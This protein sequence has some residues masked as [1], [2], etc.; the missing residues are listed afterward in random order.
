MVDGDKD[1]LSLT[2]ED[3]RF[4]ESLGLHFEDKAGFP[5]IGGRM[6]GLL[7]LASKPL[8]LGTIAELLKVSPASVST[9]IRSFHTK[10]LVEEIG[11]PGD[12]RHYYVFSD[13]A[14]EHQFDDALEGL[15]EILQIM[16]TRMERL[17]PDDAL[18]MQRFLATI[19]FFDFFRGVVQSSR[20]HWNARKKGAAPSSVPEPTRSVS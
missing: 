18:R 13:T 20:E 6:L 14:F 4:I 5:R 8:A 15:T 10:G 16:R 1:E 9:N 19:E 11:L 7:M 12:R 3:Q 17:G 2:P